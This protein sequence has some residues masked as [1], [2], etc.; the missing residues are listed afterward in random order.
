MDTSLDISSLTLDEQQDLLGRDRTRLFTA[1]RDRDAARAAFERGKQ[2]VANIDIP[3]VEKRFVAECLPA[4]RASPKL[5]GL[6]ITELNPDHGDP[7]GS[8]LARFR[9][10]FAGALSSR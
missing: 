2:Q 10:G 9:D 1:Q 7:D 4:L 5:A 6:T 3:E 8:D